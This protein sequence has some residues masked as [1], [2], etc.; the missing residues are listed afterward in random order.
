LKKL[1]DTVEML[2]H[3]TVDVLALKLSDPTFSAYFDAEA[4]K[5]ND[6]KA[7]AERAR[8]ERHQVVRAERLAR[9]E[10]APRR[11]AKAPVTSE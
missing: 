11:R 9:A 3:P 4:A 7:I 10:K 8:R 2:I 6:P 5:A 1:R